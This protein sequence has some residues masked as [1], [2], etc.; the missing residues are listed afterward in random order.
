MSR[1]LSD[2]EYNRLLKDNYLLKSQVESLKKGVFVDKEVSELKRVNKRLENKVSSRDKKI[3]KLDGELYRANLKIKQLESE[4]KALKADNEKLKIQSEKDYTNS[5]FPSSSS[6]FPRKV[7]NSREKTDRKPGG[8]IGHEGHKRKQYETDEYVFIPAEEKILNDE[9]RYVELD[10]Y[11]SRKLIDIRV[12]VRVIEYRSKLYRDMYNGK[13]I[14]ADFPEG[15]DNEIN[16]SAN[17]KAL[18]YYL[19]NYCNV[20]I[21]KTIDFI[22]QISDHRVILSKGFVSNLG[23]QF[24]QRA[25]DQNKEM[26]SLLSKADILYTDNTNARVN[27]KSAFVYV[28]TDKDKVMFNMSLHKGHQ[29]VSN[30]PVYNSLG[31]IVHDH[32]LTFYNYGKNHQECLAHILR[33]LQSSIDYEKDIS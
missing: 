24:H 17:I 3:E 21:D 7:K 12:D 8:Q 19:N 30:T 1:F 20:S 22:S 28:T 18:A 6:V 4:L 9:K 26:F 27:G 13:I 29:G 33:Y 16:Y 14:H 11:T 32:D 5:S 23:R 15:L 31:T 25:L 2:E 10:E